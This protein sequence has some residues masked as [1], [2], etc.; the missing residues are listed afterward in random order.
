MGEWLIPALFGLLIALLLLWFAVV[1]L[2]GIAQAMG[3]FVKNMASIFPQPPAPP[4]PVYTPPPV[5]TFRHSQYVPPLTQEH[6]YT[7][8][9]GLVD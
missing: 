3:V 9:R 5:Q 8:E 2:G 4:P 1:I 6:G 7:G